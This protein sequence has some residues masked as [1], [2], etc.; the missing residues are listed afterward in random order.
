M[1]FSEISGIKPK[2]INK[3][4]KPKSLLNTSNIWLSYEDYEELLKKEKEIKFYSINFG[5]FKLS[6]PNMNPGNIKIL[7]YNT[8]LIKFK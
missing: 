4:I 7:N 5:D 2:L 6:I 3:N 8:N 1:G